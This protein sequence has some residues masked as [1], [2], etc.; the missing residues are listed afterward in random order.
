[1]LK[2]FISYYRPYIGIFLLDLLAAILV[3]ACNLVFPLYS[4]QMLNGWIEDHAITWILWLALGLVGM[5]A[6][7]MGL[8]YYMGNQGHVMGAYMQA[9]M[10]RGLFRQLQ[11]L[12]C[13]FFD[14]HKT[15][16]LM[17]CMTG[18]LFDVSELA[19]HGPEDLFIS[20]VQFVGAFIILMTIHPVLTLICFICLPPMIFFV[21]KLRKSLGKASRK[22]RAEIAELNAGLENSISGIRVSKAYNAT[23]GEE[24][25]FAGRNAAFVEARRGF[26]R[27]IGLFHSGMTFGTDLLQLLV[28]VLGGVLIIYREQV[29]L[30]M[31]LVDLVTFMLYVSVFT[32]PIMKMVGFMEQ[33]ENGMSGFARF[34]TIMEAEPEADSAEASEAPVFEGALTFDDVHFSYSEG[35]E[36]LHGVSFDV[37]AGTTLA[38]VGSSGGGKTTICHLIPRFY[39]LTSGSIRIDGV[40]IRDYTLESLRG[41][42]G[43]VAQ[44]V[45]LFNATIG[46]NIAYGAQNPSEED[47][48]KA[49][50]LAGLAELI[51]ALPEGLNTPVGERGVKLSGGQKQRIS[52]A[53]VFLKNPPILILDEATSALDNITERQIQNSLNALCRGRTTIVVAHRLSTVRGA[54]EILYVE[55]GEIIERGN[56][57]SLMALGGEYAK[58]VHATEVLPLDSERREDETSFSI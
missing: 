26:C 53:R 43:V 40:D 5:Y 37:P 41:Q 55:G 17:S 30:E 36:I 35:G 50:E 22:S 8:N 10:R 54:D 27:A 33:Y 51:D 38:L 21:V 23:E 16:S 20:L 56:H 25:A 1:M 15:G 2:R 32:Q 58:L 34:C 13:T 47:I 11:R 7:K 28:L 44:D 42:I 19:H 14:N 52:I 18:D 12:P 39:D 48:R 45:F 57:E 24:R 46:E 49:A 31:D 4:R 6:I 9:D 3:S 29:G